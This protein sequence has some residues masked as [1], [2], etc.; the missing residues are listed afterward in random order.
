MQS[1]Q[2]LPGVVVR[3]REGNRR[4]GLDGMLGTVTQTFGHPSHVAIDVLL[5]NGRQELFW[6]NQLDAVGEVTG[7]ESG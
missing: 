1:N 4:P 6:P 2:A 3:V 7:A 5:D